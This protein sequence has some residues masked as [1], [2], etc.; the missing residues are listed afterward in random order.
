LSA[1]GRHLIEYLLNHCWECYTKN[2]AQNALVKNLWDLSIFCNKFY[3]SVTFS[4]PSSK[5]VGK[6]IKTIQ[7]CTLYWLGLLT[8][9]MTWAIPAWL[10]SCISAGALIYLNIH[11]FFTQT[12]RCSSLAFVYAL[13]IKN[14]PQFCFL[15]VW[16]HWLGIDKL[17]NVRIIAKAFH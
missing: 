6:Y 2:K 17:K 1:G 9:N 16:Q 4:H 14:Q 7:W 5:Y 10:I 3:S 12:F 13:I 15:T 8:L 11:Q